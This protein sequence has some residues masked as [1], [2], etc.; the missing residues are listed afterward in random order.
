MNKYRFTKEGHC[1]ELLVDGEWRKLTGC[2][3]VLSVIA[4]PFLIQW[5][6][7]QAVEYI[8]EKWGTNGLTAEQLFE[9]LEEARKAHCR[10]KEEAGQKGTD[11]HAIIEE[12]IKNAIKD[13][14]GLIAGHN[15]NEEKQV[16]HFVEWAINNKIKFLDSELGVY[17][18]KLWLGGI[19]DFVCSINGE[20]WVGDIKTGN[21][22]YPE[23]FAQTSAYQMMLSEMNLYPN[24]KGHLI[25][26]LRKD[27]TFEEKRSVSNEDFRKFFLAALDIY[28]VQQKIKGQIL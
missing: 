15:P 9:V 7:N 21:G 24:I 16:S 6:A 3:T 20:V 17:S 10:K 14:K 26:N 18:E 12:L 5:A 25:L 13:N 8:K 11:I 1:H 2:T 28:R 23:H 4:K 19:V 22:I 27:G